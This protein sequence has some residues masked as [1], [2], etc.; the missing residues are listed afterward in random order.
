MAL[1]P[2]EPEGAIGHWQSAV[3]LSGADAPRL[4]LAEALQAAGRHEEARTQFEK[5]LE[6]QPDHPV[7]RLGL[8]R[9][10]LALGQDRDCLQHLSF[11]LASP[12]T[13]KAAYSLQASV[14]ERLGEPKTAEEDARKAAQA[15][16]ERPWPNPFAAE[17]ARLRMDRRSRLTQAAQ[18]TEQG[19]AR[20][21]LALLN[22]LV[23][24]EPDFVQAWLALGH[25]CLQLGDYARAEQAL[26]VA[27]RLA[28]D[29]ADGHFYRGC[30]AYNQGK[31]A[32]AEACFRRAV[33]RKPDYALALYH[34]G[35]CRERQNDPAGASTAFQA[36]I[37][38]RPNLAEAH[39]AWAGL[40]I[41]QGRHEEADRQLR[42]TLELKPDDPAAMQML[43]QGSGKSQGPGVR[44]QG[45]G[46]KNHL[47]LTPDP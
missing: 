28:P 43:N 4:R 47:N 8:A 6:R 17:L 19:H 40:L 24:E 31:L 45:S 29:A 30:V 34:L 14:H 7:A 13:R 1:A 27:L 9:S 38:C 2:T 10:S 15:P 22:E 20:E 46:K 5:L 12:F 3:A 42:L 33:E 37:A 16:P 11:A 25:A 32:T 41:R 21:G 18:W 39:R 36:A 35:L 44:D 26:D 23:Q